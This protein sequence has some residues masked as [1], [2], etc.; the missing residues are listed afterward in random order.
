MRLRCVLERLFFL[1]LPP[2]VSRCGSGVIP[3][4]DSGGVIW[5]P[6]G[7]P[8]VR[9]VAGVAGVNGLFTFTFG[10]GSGVFGLIFIATEPDAGDAAVAGAV[11]NKG[12]FLTGNILEINSFIVSKI[13][14]PRCLRVFLR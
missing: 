5:V 11:V 14:P 4:L 1:R 8:T 10:A 2:S 3:A 12:S 7:V 13:P 9:V 6:G